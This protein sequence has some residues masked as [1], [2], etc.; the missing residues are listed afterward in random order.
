MEKRGA[1]VNDEK[2]LRRRVEALRREIIHH[3]HRY[4]VLDAPEI[5]D[6]A[7]DALMIELLAL[8]R[9]HPELQDFGSPTARVG[10]APREGFV[11]VSHPEPMQSLDNV[12]SLEGL[13]D[14]LDRQRRILPDLSGGYVCELKIDG[15]AVS[16]HYENGVFV[17]GATRGDGTVGEDVTANLRTVRTVPLTLRESLPGALEVRGE[18]YMRSED[19]AALNAEREEA[20]E[21]LFANPRNAAAGALR[22]LDPAVTA[23]R[24][25]SFFAYAVSF[26][27]R[28][29][30]ATQR[31]LLEALRRWGFATQGNEVLAS[32]LREVGAY[33]ERWREGRFSLP[34]ATDGV[35]V[36][37]DRLELRDLLGSTA[38]A[39]R[40]A[41]AYKYPPE[42]KTTRVRDIVISV[43]RTG[44][45]T[46][47]AILD[48]V[49]LAGTVVQRAS[50]HNADEVARKDVRIGDRVVVRKAGEIIPEVVRVVSEDRSGTEIPFVMP[51]RCPV[52]GTPAVRLPEEAATRCPRRSCPAQIKEGLRHFASRGGLDIRGLGEKIVD[53]LVETGRVKDLADLFDLSAA[54]LASL[55]RLG[56]KSAANMI[57]AL[58]TS[59]GR[60]LPRLLTALG[61]R[62][63]GSRV[64]ELLADRF[65]SV[66]ALTRATEEELASV[67]GVGPRI[68]ASVRAFLDSP[69][70]QETLRRLA[71]RGM[72]LALPEPEAPLAEGPWKEER[73]VFTGELRT[74]TRTEGEAL[75]A[76]LGGR[77]LGSVSSKTTLV[78]AGENSGSKLRKAQELGI[79]V[80]DEE[81][82]LARVRRARGEKSPGPRDGAS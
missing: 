47:V 49:P 44:S 31:E 24:R 35:V 66:E 7:Y 10:G 56:E 18:I 32:N 65:R 69:A 16:L 21:P 79:A 55:D 73:V 43:G 4:Y 53:R 36:K 78:V 52:C 77:A 57:Q 15:L 50:L 42:E 59:L 74:L 81:E 34:Y 80:V 28:R 11:K 67:D 72:A 30:L 63:V 17:R 40:W 48:P 20:E 9:D 14:F 60:P 12:F 46:P 25:L 13:G 26:P 22:Q 5:A 75:V 37:V 1:T 51:P 19:F 23:S 6:D 61:I 38:R 64:A 45:L 29:G 39:P 71:S 58:E 3:A 2:E 8:E 62:H 70:N 82:F 54:E 33:V 68:A 76:S 41:V 27:E